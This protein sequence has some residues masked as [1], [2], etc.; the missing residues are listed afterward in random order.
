MP[1]IACIRRIARIVR[2][3]TAGRDHPI[4]LGGEKQLAVV[5]LSVLAML[6]GA[7]A[8]HAQELARGTILD[9]VKCGA[10]PSESYATA[11]T[12]DFNYRTAAAWRPSGQSMTIRVAANGGLAAGTI[13][14]PHVI[15]LAAAGGPSDNAAHVE[16]D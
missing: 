13:A 6:A 2:R 12:E 14:F 3:R 9:D 4:G 1:R 7:S 16:A 15:G 5:F 8:V 11:G 10:D